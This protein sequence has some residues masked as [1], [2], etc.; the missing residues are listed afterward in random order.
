MWKQEYK[1][2]SQFYGRKDYSLLSKKRQKKVRNKY[3]K[4]KRKVDM[5]L[6][7][8][9]TGAI[10][11]LD[12]MWNNMIATNRSEGVC[13]IPQPVATP[14]MQTCIQKGKQ[15]MYYD[16]DCEC[17]S[18]WSAERTAQM[19]LADR[20]E[21]IR[22]KKY[23][24]LEKAYGLRDDDAPATPNELLKRIADGKFYIPEDRKNDRNYDPLRYFLWRDPSVKKDPDGFNKAFETLD[25][26][27]TK[28]E[29]AIYVKS[30]FD[31]LAA[32][33][34]FESTQFS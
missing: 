33:E 24:E 28:V 6:T 31:A 7:M 20:L 1:E 17:S 14:Q 11:S 2:I 3:N 29:D 23:R 21:T 25:A 22:S 15:A 5:F 18:P 10:Q 30:S 12:H 13:D 27:K 19:H 8:T 4:M 16:D 26:A 32:V 34:D 9:N